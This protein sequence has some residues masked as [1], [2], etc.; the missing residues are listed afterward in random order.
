MSSGDDSANRFHTT[1]W[2]LVL[3][4]R[5]TDE[6]RSQ[7]ALAL[8]C[9][10]YW[11][12]LYAFL[13]RSGHAAHEAEDI[14]QAFFAKVLEKNYLDVAEQSRGR[15]RS[16]LLTALKH[17]LA[18]ERKAAR[19][20]KRGGGKTTLSLDFAA[21]EEAYAA[22][23]VEERTPERLFERQWALRL[24]ERVFAR[25]EGEWLA[26]GK[27]DWFQTLGEFLTAGSAHRPYAEAAAKLQTTE[28]AVKT[29]VYRLRQRYREL[30][31]AEIA[32]TVSDP[33]EIEDE[34]RQLFATLSGPGDENSV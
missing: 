5:R 9:G 14:T 34:V 33:E 11:L 18:N 10:D 7:E 19:A 4:A 25:L 3:A 21:A 22:E 8:L 1:H 12:P 27:A 13:R 31:R 28:G 16:F 15:F 32:P 30:L 24:L 20:A 17:F 26:A 2:S 23:P 6:V 29:A